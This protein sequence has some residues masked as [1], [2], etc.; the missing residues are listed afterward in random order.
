MLKF[1]SVVSV[2]SGLTFHEILARAEHCVEQH[3]ELCLHCSYT[4]E[5]SYVVEVYFEAQ[6]I[7]RQ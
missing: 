3:Q 7:L 4:Y 5:R 2:A 1:S 6:S